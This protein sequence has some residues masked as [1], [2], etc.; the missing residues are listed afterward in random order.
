MCELKFKDVEAQNAPSRPLLCPIPAGAPRPPGRF[1]RFHKPQYRV[2][3]VPRSL[4]LK[5]VNGA[6]VYP[7]PA[8]PPPLPS[9]PLTLTLQKCVPQKAALRVRCRA[10]GRGRKRDTGGE[11]AGVKVLVPASPGRRVVGRWW[12]PAFGGLSLNCLDPALL[13]QVHGFS[14]P[15]FC[16]LQSQ[17]LF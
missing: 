8:H 10:A 2:T 6:Q 14:S 17:F 4:R 11:G 5:K 9:R 12:P 7:S 16:G 15:G 13:R 3:N 1:S